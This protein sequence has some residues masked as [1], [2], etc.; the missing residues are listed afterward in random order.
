MTSK[1]PYR[2]P[3]VVRVELNPDQAILSACSVMT[4]SVRNAGSQRCNATGLL[5]C[6]RFNF[7]WPLG[8]SGPRA[9]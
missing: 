6:K 1:K 8:D 7:F 5:N 4:T 3:Q 9:S 2:P